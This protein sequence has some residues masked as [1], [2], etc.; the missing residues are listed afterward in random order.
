MYRLVDTC[1][2]NVKVNML[3]TTDTTGHTVLLAVVRRLAMTIMT[4][5]RLKYY[6]SWVANSLQKPTT[7]KHRTTAMDFEYKLS[8]K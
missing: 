1:V 4:G 6:Y 2:S 3:M 8:L 5:E 7:T